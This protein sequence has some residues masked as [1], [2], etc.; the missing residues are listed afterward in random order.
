MTDHDPRAADV[1]MF[2]Q[3]AVDVAS[4]I[5]A[6]IATNP[7]AANWS[8]QRWAYEAVMVILNDQG[9]AH[10]VLRCMVGQ[11]AYDLAVIHVGSVPPW[12]EAAAHRAHIVKDDA[13]WWYGDDQDRLSDDS[14]DYQV[15][16]VLKETET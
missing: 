8:P 6:Y 1:E 10:D 12:M 9:A 15:L 3:N 13:G 14:P 5:A 7:D 2:G 16:Y 4:R 11:A